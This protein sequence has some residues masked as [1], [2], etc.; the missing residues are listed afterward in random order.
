MVVAAAVTLC[1]CA[2][3]QSV[4]RSRLFWPSYPDTPRIEWIGHYSS[5]KDLIGSTSQG[6]FGLI[7]G[8]ESDVLLQR[9][10]SVASDGKGKV[11]VT[12]GDSLSVYVFD[13]ISKKVSRFGGISYD[14]VFKHVNGVA[15]DDVGNA[16]ASDSS[17]RKIFV[18]TPQN[19]PL[20]VIDVSAH[21]GGI[22]RLAIDKRN[23]HIVIPDVIKHQI[24][25]TDLDGNHIQT[26]G[27]KGEGDG[28]FNLPIAVAIEKEGTIVVADAYNAR[29]QRFTSKGVFVG[30]FGKR[31]DSIGDFSVI[32]GVA[33]DSEDHI[34]VTDGREHRVTIFSNKG[35][36][37]TTLGGK[38]AQ[39]EG[40]RSVAGGFLL[41]QGIFVDQNDRIFIVDQLN[42]RFQVFQYL[43]ARYLAEFPL[44][45][46]VGQE[47][48]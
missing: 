22:G 2:S 36:L 39:R 1:S 11:Y 19:T 14:S 18:V 31:G 8:E 17:Q 21:A 6:L 33:V 40:A 30:K 41:P 13:F 47:V 46:D 4:T 16:Y 29:I 15:V 3:P 5:D 23:K 45:P 24:V 43:N 10:M 37:L 28:E 25:I 9:P 27:S 32:K 48:K 38:Y 44:P 7:T 20:K 26:F 12:D 35:E 42:R 34:Y